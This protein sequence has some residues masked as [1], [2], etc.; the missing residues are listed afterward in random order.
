MSDARW[1]DPRKYRDPDRSDERPR[2]YA[3]R[4]R[5]SDDPRDCLTHDLRFIAER[6]REDTGA[7]GRVTK[8]AAKPAEVNR[9][10]ASLR[11]AFNLAVQAGRLINRPHFPML[12]ERN[13]RRGF[14]DRDQIDR[15]CAALKATETADDGR[16]K[17]SELANVV[18]FAFVTG[19]RTAS[20]V[21]PLDGGTSIGTGA[22]FDWT[23][24]R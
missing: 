22:V 5:E 14:L 9:E 19:W 10:L 24:T 2:V 3:E 4:D 1:N 18:L 6:Q 15:I 8:R 20:E 17:A 23:R 16:K 13:T 21:L 7:D 11:R 12:M